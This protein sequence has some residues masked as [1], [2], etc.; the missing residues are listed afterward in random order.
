MSTVCRFATDMYCRSADG[1][2]LNSAGDKIEFSNDEDRFYLNDDNKW[3]FDSEV[4][5]DETMTPMKD[6]KSLQSEAYLFA[7]LLKGPG[8]SDYWSLEAT[9]FALEKTDKNKATTLL[10]D[11]LPQIEQKMGLSRY[12]NKFQAANMKAVG[13]SK[14]AEAG[15]ALASAATMGVAM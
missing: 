14:L 11:V 3:Q 5:T 1:F 9:G 15:E 4:I 12:T 2:Y 6:P 13:E 8:A 7:K 10:K